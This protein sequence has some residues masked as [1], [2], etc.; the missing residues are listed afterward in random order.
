MNKPRPLLGPSIL[1]ADLSN[2]SFE[3][4]D[5]LENGA[6]YIHLDVMDGSNKHKIIDC[7]Q[8]IYILFVF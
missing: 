3:C 5:L 6:D 4:K 7:N 2:L 8:S 1:N